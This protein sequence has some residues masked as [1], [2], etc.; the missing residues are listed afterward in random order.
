MGKYTYAIIIGQGLENV[1]HQALGQ[2]F[3]VWGH[4]FS[5]YRL[6]LSQLI[7]YLFFPLSH[8]SFYNC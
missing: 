8:N 2:H 4:N 5:L 6:I 1:A 7:T 3:Q